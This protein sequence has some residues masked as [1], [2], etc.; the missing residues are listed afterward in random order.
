MS[1]HAAT[2]KE[3]TRLLR[4]ARNCLESAPCGV[5]PPPVGPLVGSIQEFEDFLDHNELELAWDALAE[6]ARRTSDAERCWERLAEA[7]R[8]MQLPGKADA[9]ARH[10]APH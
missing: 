1:G 7:A 9:A 10:S 6:V 5:G 2:W 8:L 4:E 3:V